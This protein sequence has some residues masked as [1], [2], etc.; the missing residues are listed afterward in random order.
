MSQVHR[1]ST[2]DINRV[3]DPLTHECV[4]IQLHLL[5]LVM[6]GTNR[7]DIASHRSFQ[8]LDKIITKE[9]RG[10]PKARKQRTYRSSSLLS[11]HY[12]S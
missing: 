11:L 2:S 9:N 10:K 1:I 5:S 4:N 8:R 6:Q 12:R 3:L 7:P